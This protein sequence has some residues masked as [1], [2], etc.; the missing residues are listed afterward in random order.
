MTGTVAIVGLGYVGLPLAVEFG[1]VMP[2]I[3]FDVSKQKIENFKKNLDPTGEVNTE[4]FLSAKM[5]KV[6]AEPEDLR[7]ADYLVVAVPTPVD[8]A[9]RPDF[10][11]LESASR[12]HS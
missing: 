4:Q 10:S 9:N 5:L 3:G 1:R 8:Q 12:T 2:T 11:P 6:T 7:Q